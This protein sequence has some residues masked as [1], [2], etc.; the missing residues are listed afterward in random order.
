MFPEEGRP[1]P[2]A[3]RARAI[4]PVDAGHLPPGRGARY[5]VDAGSLPLDNRAED[6]LRIASL[7]IGVM[8]P[9]SDFYTALELAEE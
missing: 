3:P 6:A 4:Y 2:P 7:A 1:G 8:A 5:P 9:L